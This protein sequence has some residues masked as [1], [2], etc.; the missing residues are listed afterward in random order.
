MSP[1]DNQVRPDRS[2]G[3]LR[4]RNPRKIIILIISHVYVEN[5]IEGDFTDL[6]EH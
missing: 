4:G 3:A 5:N 6:L 2:T 1:G